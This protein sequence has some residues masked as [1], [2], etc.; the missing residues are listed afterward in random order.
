[1]SKAFALS[2]L[3]LANDQ[4]WTGAQRGAFTALTSAS[5]HIAVDMALGNNFSHT[6]TENTELDAPT[7]AVAGQSGVIHFTQHASSPKTLSF[8]SFWLFADG[9]DP[10]ITATNS[11]VDVLTYVV[12]PAGTSA[13]CAI[14]GAAA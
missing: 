5:G 13:I 8:A 11:A 14:V 12:N 7:N 10:T 1:M 2:Q 9:T 4:T 3:A 6:F